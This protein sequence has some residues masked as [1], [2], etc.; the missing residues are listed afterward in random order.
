MAE[1]SSAVVRV[2]PTLLVNWPWRLLKLSSTPGRCLGAA[3]SDWKPSRG[4]GMGLTAH[5][6]YATIDV[7]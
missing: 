7:R 6:S 3:S 1:A 4:R 5:W 2:C